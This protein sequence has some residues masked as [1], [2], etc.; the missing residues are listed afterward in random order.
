MT[1]NRK[2]T[3]MTTTTCPGCHGAGTE[4]S[5]TT[6]A[7]LAEHLACDECGPDCP[8]DCGCRVDAEG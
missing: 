5:G 3:T 6:H 4:M 2:D 7:G 8:Q 1:T